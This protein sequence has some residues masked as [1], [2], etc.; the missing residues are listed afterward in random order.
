MS[1]ATDPRRAPMKPPED[2]LTFDPVAMNVVNRVAAGSVLAGD[3]RFEGGVLV[4]GTLG[5]TVHV[6]GHLVVWGGA[7][8][9]GHLHVSGDVYL[10]GHLGEPDAPV[11]QTQVE[12]LG[13]LYVA[14]TGVSSA[15]VTARQLRLYDGADLRGP[16]HMLRLR[17]PPPILTE[18]F[19]SSPSS[20]R[21]R[22][23]PG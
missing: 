5:G 1:C 8:A 21:P 11:E 2:A 14:H 17:K 12:C 16:F 9:R 23:G 6:G 19:A 4:Q 20:G 15:R 7:L 22:P 18:R 3:L 13:T 10:F